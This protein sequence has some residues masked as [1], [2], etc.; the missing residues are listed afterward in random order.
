MSRLRLFEHISSLIIVTLT[1]A[2]ATALIV[3]VGVVE[4][5]MYGNGLSEI[6]MAVGMLNVLSFLFLGIAIYVS[7]V[8]ITNAFATLIAGRR[9]EIALLR[10]IGSTSQQQRFGILREGTAIGVI[11]AILGYLIGSVGMFIALEIAVSLGQIQKLDYQ[12]FGLAALLPLLIIVL[13]TCLA[14]WL[15]S[16]KVLIVT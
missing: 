4:T 12:T 1:S 5:I 8:V 14:S 9:K 10:L 3:A 6:G 11:G 13:V 7:G 16:R 15:G 2:F